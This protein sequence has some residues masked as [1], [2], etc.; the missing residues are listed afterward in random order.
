[1][2]K[3]YMIRVKHVSDK[4][5]ISYVV[6]RIDNRGGLYIN[7]DRYYGLV[8]KDNEIVGAIKIAKKY[9]GTGYSI[10][11]ELVKGLNINTQY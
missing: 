11:K 9:F 1:M 10:T 2:E 3:L 6:S 8:F 5:N 7:Y 4:Y